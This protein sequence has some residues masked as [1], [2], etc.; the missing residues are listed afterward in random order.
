MI[1]WND[2]ERVMAEM[3]A[4]YSEYG[5]SAEERMGAWLKSINLNENAYFRFGHAMTMMTMESAEEEGWNP[6][7]AIQAT[8]QTAFFVGWELSRQFS[9]GTGETE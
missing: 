9:V 4:I 6:H 2:I 5:D 8:A 1:E 3:N 7:I